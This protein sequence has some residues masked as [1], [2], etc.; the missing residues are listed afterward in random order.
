M[1]TGRPYAV[2]WALERCA[3]VVQAFF[4]GEEGGHA[5]AAVLSGA[6][7]PSGRMPLSVPRSVAAM[8]STYLHARLA[9]P[10]SVSNLDP[11]PPLA[12]GH[13]LSY[14]TFTHTDLVV[15][16]AVPAGGAVQATVRVTNTGT[17]RGAD[18]VQLYGHDVVASLVRP[19]AQLLAYARV[20]LDPG[21]SATVT[22]DVP[23]TLLAF[24]DLDLV[25]VVEPG[26]V[27]L[28]VGPDCRTRECEATVELTGDVHRVTTADRRRS[29]VTVTR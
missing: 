3:A 6:V 8:P 2:G 25:R 28:W 29:E 17:R 27:E 9:G 21:E 26:A 15:D 24:A 10:S 19:V 20:E 12:F 13:G 22:F 18:V 23:S 4:P 5:V 7:V 16:Q 11:E 1:V 14:T